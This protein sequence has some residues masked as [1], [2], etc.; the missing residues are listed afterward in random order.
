MKSLTPIGLLCLLTL[1]SGVIRLSAQQTFDPS[2]TATMDAAAY[3]KPYPPN[4]VVTYA[5]IAGDFA[6][7]QVAASG[8]YGDHRVTVIGRVAALNNG[9]SD[10][11]V[12]V[13]TLQDPSASLPAVKCSFLFGFLPQNSSLEISG[14]G[15]QATLVRRDRSGAILG[16]EVY[17]SA[18]QK[19]AIKGDFKDLKVGDI[20]LT[21]CTLLSKDRRKELEA[22]LSSQ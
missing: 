4:G 17:L 22:G 21:A 13:V 11:K 6:S 15:S 5:T 9:N 20:V 2:K 1:L 18:G 19:V 12:L 10:N 7:N 3:L 16:R 8:K 14:D